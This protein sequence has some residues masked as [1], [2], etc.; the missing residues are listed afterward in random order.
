MDRARST[1][2]QVS[3]SNA[4]TVVVINDIL[5]T[6]AASF[7]TFHAL[8]VLDFVRDQACVARTAKF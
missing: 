3:T 5:R 7:S 4:V 1:T 6:L 2:R 8:Q